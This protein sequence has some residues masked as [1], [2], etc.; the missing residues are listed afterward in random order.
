MPKK[1]S[2][3]AKRARAAARVGAKY[4]SSL[5]AERSPHPLPPHLALVDEV[6]L[7][8]GEQMVVDGLR[9]SPAPGTA[10]PYAW[11]SRSPRSPPP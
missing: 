11:P 9:P 6:A 5:R 7:A 2:T 1:Q 4:T 8:E 3:C 10:C